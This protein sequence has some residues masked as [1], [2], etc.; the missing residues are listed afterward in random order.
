[1]L[2]IS[3]KQML[4]KQDKA[5]LAQNVLAGAR[6]MVWEGASDDSPSTWLAGKACLRI[7]VGKHRKI[8]KGR[9]EI[10]MKMEGPE[11]FSFYF[12]PHRARVSKN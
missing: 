5:E 8:V 4:N 3:S 10:E 9:L 2:I 11:V 12:A 1:M 6:V 7:K